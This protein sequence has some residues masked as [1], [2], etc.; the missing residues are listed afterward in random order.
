MGFAI[1]EFSAIR[2]LIR[3]HKNVLLFIILLITL[4]IWI[5]NFPFLDDNSNFTKIFILVFATLIILPV[6]ILVAYKNFLESRDLK[7]IFLTYLT[8]TFLI[9]SFFGFAY[10]TADLLTKTK[11]I[12]TPKDVANGNFLKNAD[13][14]VDGKPAD[15]LYFSSVTYF[16]LGYGD[17]YP[18]G[19][20]IRFLS[21]LEVFIGFLINI[22]S[23]GT[24]I[25]NLNYQK[26]NG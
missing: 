15:Y 13:G 26:N 12:L 4:L 10:N 11:S 25:S 20:L 21:Q 16:T 18:V 6:S 22:F 1:L 5:I 24:V 7:Y 17:L 8:L 3:Y 23:A 19:N 2:N 14:L 9:I